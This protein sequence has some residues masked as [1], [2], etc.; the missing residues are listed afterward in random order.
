[1]KTIYHSQ[2][3]K[4]SLLLFKDIQQLKQSLSTLVANAINRDEANHWVE[5]EK[6][7]NNYF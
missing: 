5:I 4:I 6:I 1:M 3:I 2:F 7:K